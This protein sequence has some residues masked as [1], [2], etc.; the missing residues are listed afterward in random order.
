[1]SYTVKRTAVQTA[2]LMAILTLGSKVMGF[3]R[4]MVI[5]GF[6]GTSYVVDAYVMALAIP[7]MIFLGFFT[8]MDTAYMP[9]FSKITENEG[10]DK[11]IRFTSETI[12]LALIIAVISAVLGGL[13]SKQIV[14]IFASGF[15]GE[16]AVLTSKFIKISFTFAIFTSVAG[17]LESFLKY[18]NIFLAPLVIGYLQNTIVIAGI[19]VSAYYNN[20]LLVLGW[21]LAYVVRL[22]IVWFIAKKN[23]FKYAKEH[24][25]SHSAKKIMA[26]SMPVFFGSYI[27]QINVFVDKTLASQLQEGSIAALNYGN[28]LV[29]MITGLTVS[30]MMIIIYPKMTQAQSLGNYEYFNKMVSTGFNLI[31]IIMIPSTLG[32]MLYSNQIV[33]IVYER[34]N[35]DSLATALTSEAFLYYSAGLLFISLNA[36]LVQTYYSMHDM[37][38]PMI[39]AAIGVII[40]IVLNL[41]LV[42]YMAHGGLALATSISAGCNIIFLYYGLHK[43]YPN[44][45]MISSIQKILKIFFAAGI[46]I[47]V[48][49][50]IYVMLDTTIWMPNMV[51]M[52]VVVLLTSIVYLALLRLAKI[53]EL[54]MIR[55]LIRIKR[56]R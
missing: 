55:Q 1:M 26:L 35:F 36:L 10:E 49:K 45:K 53:E 27:N 52:F 29:N 34:G 32:A 21:M 22:L 40:N 8:A 4:E 23:G 47:A 5:A 38:A 20:Y 31:C 14:A 9:L 50:A 18:K 51:R 25:L 2:L 44:V 54:S 37:K 28:L 24:K 33:Q 12:L 56:F 41:V 11:G 17:V 16:T 43:R 7:S 30:I 15:S 48:S 19:I 39:Y 42:K 6:F 46:S 3:V 13:F